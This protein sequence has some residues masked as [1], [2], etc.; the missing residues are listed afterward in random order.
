M[1]TRVLKRGDIGDDVVT[2]QIKLAG[3]RGTVWD[4]GFGPGTE[5]QVMQFQKDFMKL[6]NP[7]GIVD[8]ST[9][10]AIDMLA[11]KYPFNFS[12]LKCPCGQ[13][14][15]WG[16]GLYKGQYDAGKPKVEAYYNYEYPGIHKVVL[17]TTRAACFYTG[18]PIMVNSGYRCSIEEAKHSRMGSNHHGKAIDT[19]A[20]LK[21]GDLK[22]DDMAHCDAIRTTMVDKCNC[23][24][25]WAGTNKK[26]LEPNDI[27]PTWVHM[28]IRQYES[29]Y[30]LDKFF[31]RG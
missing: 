21:P 3:F 10:A 12:Q 31:V 17:W 19:D 11:S 27:A 13:C 24:I 30:L 25:G 22:K 23:Q 4:G 8:Q 1:F 16:Q 29:K 15:G 7:T 5:L 28:D 14:S 20:P 26:S 2:L 9:S 18:N 6:L